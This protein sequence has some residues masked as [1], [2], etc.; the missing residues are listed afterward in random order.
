MRSRAPTQGEPGAAPHRGHGCSWASLR[1]GV[2]GLIVCGTGIWL[3]QP[4]VIIGL[5]TALIGTGAPTAAVAAVAK[6][7]GILVAAIWNFALYRRLVFRPA[8]PSR[9]HNMEIAPARVEWDPDETEWCRLR[10]DPAYAANQ[11]R[12]V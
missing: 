5:T 2:S 10:I 6:A 1:D 11:R 9:P 4:L 3:I 7:A 8:D 12:R